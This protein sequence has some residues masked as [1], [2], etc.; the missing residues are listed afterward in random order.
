MRKPALSCSCCGDI[1]PIVLSGGAAG[2]VEAG[3]SYWTT[4]G[5]FGLVSLCLG[6]SE[7]VSVRDI[8]TGKFR[9]RNSL[10]LLLD[11]S[12]LFT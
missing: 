12:R 2:L 10:P 6:C 9:P 8:D 3:Y 11:N 4:P 1:F 5:P 7:V